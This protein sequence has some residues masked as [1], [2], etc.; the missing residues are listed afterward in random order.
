MPLSES[1][2]KAILEK[3]RRLLKQQIKWRRHLHQYPELSHSEFETTAFLKQVVGKIGLKTIP[4]KLPSG[5]LAEIRGPRP[6]RTMA[7]RSDIDAL[8]VTERTAVPFKS[9]IEGRMHACGHDVHMAI[10]LGAATV[11]HEL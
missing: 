6:G 11:L 8:P 2:R 3:T 7:L 4:I 9:K 10:L 1:L 5:L